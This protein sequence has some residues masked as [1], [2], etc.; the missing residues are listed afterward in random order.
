MIYVGAD[1]RGFKLK[2]ELVAYLE[3]RGYKVADV[4]TT[5]EEAAD[6]PMIS[7]KVAKKV[8]EDLNNRGVLICGSGA[9]VCITANK[10]KG[11]RAALAWNENMAKS[12]RNDDNAN[13]LCLAADY[14]T[15]DAA[16]AIAQAFLDTSFAGEERFKRR[17]E[18]IRA[19]EQEN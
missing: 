12:L 11:I 10:F 5:S 2:Q 9:G 3:D 19:I 15:P 13:V 1:H 6:Y 7:E 18:E 14:L 8:Q 17:L 16:K 4:G